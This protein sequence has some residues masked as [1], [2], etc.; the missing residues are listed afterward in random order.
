MMIAIDTAFG[1]LAD[2]HRR[3]AIELL[4]GKPHT[5]GELAR[6]IGVSAPTMSKHLRQL[7][8]AELVEERHPQLDARVRIYS[9]RLERLSLVRDWLAAAETMWAEQL[10]AFKRHIEI[11]AGA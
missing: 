11:D 7:R 3:R 9:L 6:A 4:S 8:M 5:A 10:S 2:P 1:A